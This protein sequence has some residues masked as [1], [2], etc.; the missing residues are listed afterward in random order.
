[1]SLPTHFTLSNGSKIPSV[2]LGTWQSKPGEVRDAVA[3]ALK[4]GYRHIDCAWGYQNEGEVGE[5]IKLS[6]VPREEIWI[7]SK[8]FEFH[9]KHARHA[10][11]DTLSKLGV[12]YLDLYLMHWNVALEPDVPADGSLPRKP[13]KDP[14]TGKPQ[15]DRV[16]SDNPLPCWRDMEALVE[17]GLVKNIGVS[18]FNIRRLR[19]LLKEAKIKPVANQVELSFTCPQPE[20]LAFCHKVNVL[21]QAYSPLG[22]TGASHSSLAAVDALA[23]KHNVQG[24]NILISWQVGRGANPLPK[25][26]TPARIANN[27][28]LVDLSKEEIA[29]LEESANSQPFKKVC[30]QSEDFD[31]DIFEASHPQNN[32]KAQALL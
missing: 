26:V 11:E 32:D 3:A 16:L 13:L 23:K 5:G 12:G 14:K 15:V 22:S 9:H 24:A 2:G 30:D 28:K 18:N 6:G 1:M 4:A 7:T 8:L 17:A 29:Q 21:P 31:Y 10:V 20:L 25:S 19:A 27:L